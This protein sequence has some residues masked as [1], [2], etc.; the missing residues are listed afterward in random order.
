MLISAAVLI[1]SAS[2]A[3][4]LPMAP[5]LIYFGAFV[6]WIILCAEAVFAAPLWAVMHLSPSGDDVMGGAKAGYMMLLGVLLRPA[7]IVMGFI[8]A[9][10]AS[11]KL[12]G[13]FNQIFFPAFKMAM[14]GS[15]VGLGTSVVMIGIYF[16]ALVMLF[17]TIFGLIHV[18]P[19]KL[20]RWIGGG[21]EQLGETS[22]GMSQAGH[23]AHQTTIA[24]IRTI[25]QQGGLGGLKGRGPKGGGEGGSGIGGGSR[26][27]GGSSGQD[28]EWSARVDGPGPEMTEKFDKVAAGGA[29]NLAAGASGA[30]GGG[31]ANP[32][33]LDGGKDGQAA[34]SSG[35]EPAKGGALG[36][37]ALGINQDSAGPRSAPTQEG[38]A[39]TTDPKQGSQLAS[40]APGREPAQAFSEG[41]PAQ[42]THGKQS[43]PIDTPS[44]SK[45]RATDAQ[46]DGPLTEGEQQVAGSGQP[47]SRVAGS[48]AETSARLDQTTDPKA[49]AEARDE[50]R[51]PAAA[52][53]EPSPGVA[54]RQGRKQAQGD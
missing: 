38:A 47:S 18:I 42:E 51:A 21:H 26:N 48:R 9:L 5:F 16:G 49:R 13:A 29:K 3:V 35:R 10:I 52:K 17:H 20:L 7:L 22:K 41:A 4:Y 44:D 39:A 23:S 43:Q 27:G 24:S 31:A 34:V 25:Q 40:Q 50:R 54:D 33:G 8:F 45:A 11:E 12:V 15:V 53:S 28:Q 14:V 1:M 2:I 30:S 19:D 32:A 6:G 46:E 37:G 36:L